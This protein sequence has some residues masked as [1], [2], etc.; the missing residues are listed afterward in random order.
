MSSISWN[1]ISSSLDLLLLDVKLWLESFIG[2]TYGFVGAGAG[3]GL[4]VV[5]VVVVGL[6]VVNYTYLG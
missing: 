1:P 2:L 4:V 3:A 6:I 5:V